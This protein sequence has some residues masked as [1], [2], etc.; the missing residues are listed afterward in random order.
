VDALTVVVLLAGFAA[1]V[2]GGEVLVRGGSGLARSFGLSPLV[3][4]LTVVAFATSAPEFAVTLDAT[5]SGSPGIAVGNVVGS[6]VAN[7]LLVLGVAALLLPVAVR[8]SL[9]RADVPIV[10]G[11]S[12]LL[13]LL[14]LDGGVSRLDGLLLF[15]LLVAYIVFSVR[16]GRR[17]EREDPTPAPPTPRRPVRDGVLVLVGVVLLVVGARWL[18]SGASEVAEAA[19]LSDLVVGLTVVALGTSLPELATS[20]IAAVRGEREMALGNALGSNVFNIGAVMGLAAAI[21]PDG[22]PVATSAIRFDLPV[23]IAVAVALLPIVFTG[24]TIARWEGALLLAYY[25]AYVA[26]L[27]LAAGEH[28]ALEGYSTAM[29]FFVMPLTA[30][31]LVILV[32]YEIGVIRGRRLAEQ[33]ARAAGKPPQQ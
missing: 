5:L 25:V 30:L 28:E 20:I 19:G 14:S 3:V 21:A 26:F 8:S 11:L 29:L 31:T 33:E 15:G 10:I 22:I 4:G 23:M 17:Q 2:A 9:V 12:V 24:L 27:L 1:L 7:V 18:V 6:N 32:T 13:F 16:L